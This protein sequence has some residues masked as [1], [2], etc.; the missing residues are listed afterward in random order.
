[1]FKKTTF[2]ILLLFLQNTFSQEVF[3]KGYFINNDNKKNDCLIKINSRLNPTE[4]IYKNSNDAKQQIKTIKSVKEF[5]IYNTSKYIRKTVYID[6][7]SDILSN[8]SSNKKPTLNKEE[9]FLKVLIEGNANLYL[10]ES[11][12]VIRYFYNKENSNIEQLIYKRY[13][14]ENE[15]NVSKNQEYKRQLWNNLKCESLSIIDANK[16]DYK[17]TELINF[18]TK[19][20]QCKN[21]KYT[22]F[23]NTEKKDLFNITIRPAFNSSS[24]S[25]YEAITRNKTDFGNDSGFRFGI[26]AEFIIN[27]IKTNKWSIFFEPTYQSYKSKLEWKNGSNSPTYYMDATYTSI[28]IPIGI[29][30]YFSLNNTSKI[31]VNGAMLVDIPFNSSID[32]NFSPRHLDVE[33]KLNFAF[34]AGL[35]FNDKYS[36]EARYLTNRNLVSHYQGWSSKYQTLSIILGYTLF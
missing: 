9:L 29:R 31:F 21:S 14:K 19:Y 17:K 6:R 2:I 13:K 33:T 10:F 30:Y 23:E 1:M 24:L 5:G 36:L 34:G 35:K 3:K 32:F 7:S 25:I 22:R 12:S 11:K 28:E 8:L 4:F 15:D 26:E 16:L 20:N 18:F 27:S